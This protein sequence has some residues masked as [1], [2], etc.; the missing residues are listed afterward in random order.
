MDHTLCPTSGLGDGVGG[1]G[2]WAKGFS[3]WMEKGRSIEGNTAIVIRL[4][5]FPRSGPSVSA[6]VSG[7]VELDLD[8][9]E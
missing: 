5:S 8:L 6:G 3:V 9:G 1:N 2:D 7:E 4:L